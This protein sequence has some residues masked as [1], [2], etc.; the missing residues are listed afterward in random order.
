MQEKQRK[1]GNNNSLYIILNFFNFICKYF[2]I[3]LRSTKLY[4]LLFPLFPLI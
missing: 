4:K 2:F 1:H 3:K